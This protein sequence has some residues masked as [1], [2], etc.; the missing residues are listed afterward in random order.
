MNALLGMS[1]E[2]LDSVANEYE[3]DSWD[4]SKL[5]K[6]TAGRPPLFEEAIGTISFKETDAQHRPG[7]RP[8]EEPGHKPFRLH[9]E[10]CRP[11][12]GVGVRSPF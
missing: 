3:P 7:E 1:E 8:C 12:P 10:A 2:E 5:G 6:S 11:R 9:E 4:A